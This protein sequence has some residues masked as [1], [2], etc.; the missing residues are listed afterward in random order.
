MADTE[1]K[2]LEI[3]KQ[4]EGEQEKQ[5]D[6]EK[7]QPDDNLDN[8]SK[9]KSLSGNYPILSASETINSQNIPGG[10]VDTDLTDALGMSVRSQIQQKVNMEPDV[11]E[12]LKKC[13]K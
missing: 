8:F 3:E 6:G 4:N 12:I 1:S 2:D 13:V 9:S 7:E 11:D 10:P 5:D